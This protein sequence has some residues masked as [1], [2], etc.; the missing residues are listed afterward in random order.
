MRVVPKTY[1][2][3]LEHLADGKAKPLWSFPWR[4]GSNALDQLLWRGWVIRVVER[5]TADERYEIT[6]LGKAVIEGR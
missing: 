3:A 4:I 5:G 2:A 1:R 6:E